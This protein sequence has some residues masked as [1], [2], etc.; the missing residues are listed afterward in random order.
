[1]RLFCIGV[2]DKIKRCAQGKRLQTSVISASGLRIFCP[3][4]RHTADHRIRCTTYRF[5]I[6]VVGLAKGEDNFLQHT[7]HLCT[8]RDRRRNPSY[9]VMQ[10]TPLCASTFASKLTVEPFSSSRN[11]AAGLD[12]AILFRALYIPSP[13]NC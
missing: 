12:L 6:I 3:S 8:F 1:L 7:V 9:V 10:T 2:P 5:E 13:P 4:S 11:P